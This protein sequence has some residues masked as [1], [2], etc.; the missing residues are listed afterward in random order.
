M[1]CTGITERLMHF[2]FGKSVWLDILLWG[3]PVKKAFCKQPPLALG[4]KHGEGICGGSGHKATYQYEHKDYEGKY[5][6]RITKEDYEK[7]VSVL[8]GLN[9]GNTTDSS[10]DTTLECVGGSCPLR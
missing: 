4:I 7:R 6:K 8:K 1:F 3:L 9:F 2:D 5:L 10:V